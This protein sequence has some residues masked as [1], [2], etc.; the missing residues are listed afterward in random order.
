MGAGRNF[1]KEGGTI[2]PPKKK[3][4]YKEKKASRIK[5]TGPPHGF[6]HGGSAYTCPHPPVGAH[7]CVGCSVLEQCRLDL[8]SN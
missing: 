5:K 3:G 6:F 8:I 4:P 1:C 7:N 2:P